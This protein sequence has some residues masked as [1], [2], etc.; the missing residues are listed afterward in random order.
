MKT[1]LVDT[2]IILRFLLKDHPKLSA[3]AKAII[4]D[5]TIMLDPVVVAETVWVLSSV[6][7]HE[8]ETITAI[9]ADFIAQDAIQTPQKRVLLEALRLYGTTSF[10]YVDCWLLVT[11]KASAVQLVSQD[12]KLAKEFQKATQLL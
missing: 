9:L 4:L 3:E 12:K 6:Y 5:N 10:A 8:R 1:V 2:N 7:Q 11:A